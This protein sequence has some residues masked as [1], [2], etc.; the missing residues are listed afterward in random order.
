MFK[1]L[2]WRDHMLQICLQGL[3]SYQEDMAWP[4]GVGL[5]AITIDGE[6]VTPYNGKIG[7]TMP[8]GS[9]KGGRPLGL[10]LSRTR[11]K[12]SLAQP[13]LLISDTQ[14]RLMKFELWLSLGDASMLNPIHIEISTSI[15]LVY[16]RTWDNESTIESPFVD[17]YQLGW[18]A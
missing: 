10:I 15:T 12:A 6:M 1:L 18:L 9:P 5:G 13:D 11:K 3:M 2:K 17:G 7:V 4:K 16:M 8:C 14:I